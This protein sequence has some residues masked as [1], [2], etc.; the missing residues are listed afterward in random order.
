MGPACRRARDAQVT[1]TDYGGNRSAQAGPITRVFPAW[2]STIWTALGAR[3]RSG[4]GPLNAAAAT[5]TA[6]ALRPGSRRARGSWPRPAGPAAPA[7]RSPAN[8]RRARRAV[9]SAQA[10]PAQ[11]AQI[12]ESSTRIGRFYI[13]EAPLNDPGRQQKRRLAPPSYWS[14]SALVVIAAGF[15]LARPCRQSRASRGCV[16]PCRC[17][18]AGSRAWRARHHRGA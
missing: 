3:P 6:R 14:A 16:P 8:R 11:A 2:S 9:S 13:P 18:G 5:E 12:S 1:A 15:R 4:P 17:A 10:A 7:R